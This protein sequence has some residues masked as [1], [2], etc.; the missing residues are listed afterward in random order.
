MDTPFDERR[1]IRLEQRVDFLFRHL[2]LDPAT[3]PD[4]DQLPQAYYDALNAGNKV[5]A[6][7]IYRKV[8][9]ASLA[10]SKR[11]VDAAARQGGR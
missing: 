3:F 10:D 8:T 7:N 5:G 11:A 1:M 4:G 9:G 6:I 2:G